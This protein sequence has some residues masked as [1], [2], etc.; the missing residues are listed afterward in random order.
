MCSH[1]NHDMKDFIQWSRAEDANVIYTLIQLET[2][3]WNR[4]LRWVG[5]SLF[6]DSIVELKGF[7]WAYSCIECQRCSFQCHWI[8]KCGSN[9]NKTSCHTEK[10]QSQ[11]ICMIEKNLHDPTRVKVHLFVIPV[12]KRCNCIL[13]LLQQFNGSNRWQ[14]K[15]FPCSIKLNRL[16][17]PFLFII[18]SMQVN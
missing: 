6:V 1:A 15:A 2:I 16:Y 4:E 18:E 7:Y 3:N 11:L 14:A 12:V 10:R 13:S 5:A 9:S 17:L 8:R